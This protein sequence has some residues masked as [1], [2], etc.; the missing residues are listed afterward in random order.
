MS[1][2]FHLNIREGYVTWIHMTWHAMEGFA[3]VHDVTGAFYYY[4]KLVTAQRSFCSIRITNNLF[5]DH[6]AW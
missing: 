6:S 3:G 1:L 2:V 5:F 4:Y